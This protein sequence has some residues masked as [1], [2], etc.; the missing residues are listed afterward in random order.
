MALTIQGPLYKVRHA[1][2]HLE[3][4]QDQLE[5]WISGRP[6]RLAIEHESGLEVH[7]WT[8]TL[9]ELFEAP[10]VLGLTFGDYVHNLRSALDQLAWA[11]SVNNNSGK[12]P[13]NAKLVAFPVAGNPAQFYDAPVLRNLTWEQATVLES[14]QP[15]HGGDAQKALGHLH[16]FWNDDKHRLVQ[17]V[18]ARVKRMPVFGLNDIGTVVEEWFEAKRPLKADTKIAYVKAIPSGLVASWTMRFRASG[19]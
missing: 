16:A 19:T 4:L 9:A 10:P 17:P 7:T 13:S 14:F 6:Y 8:F 18:I 3:T 12:D 15:Y 11:L 5:T 2:Q 1:Q